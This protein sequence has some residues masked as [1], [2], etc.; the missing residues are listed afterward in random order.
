LSSGDHL[1]RIA[2]RKMKTMAPMPIKGIG[3]VI[4]SCMFLKLNHHIELMPKTSWIWICQNG[5]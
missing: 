3:L 2:Q 4:R 5:F 1:E